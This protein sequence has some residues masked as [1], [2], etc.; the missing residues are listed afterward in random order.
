MVEIRM[1]KTEV[2]KQFGISRQTLYNILKQNRGF[3]E[4]KKL[5]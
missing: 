4:S 3:N 2:A 5:G 1:P